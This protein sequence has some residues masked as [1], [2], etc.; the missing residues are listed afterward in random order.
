MSSPSIGIVG[1][2]SLLGK[3]LREA[4][5]ASKLAPSIQLIGAE[6]EEAGKVLLEEED[7]A[8]ITPLDERNLASADIIMLAGS[9]ESSRKAWSLLEKRGDTPVIDLTRSLEDIGSSRLVAP[10]AG[11]IAEPG[12]GGPLLVAH[13]AAVA[14]AMFLPRLSH[15]KL[16]RSVV[17]V[18]EPVSERGQ[19]GIEE[20]HQQTLKLFAFHSLPKAV[21]DTQVAYAMVA[22]YGA[23]SPHSLLQTELTIERHLASLLA[24][25]ACPMP[26][27][28]LIQAPV[29]HGYSLSVWAEFDSDVTAEELATDFFADNFDFRGDDEEI[30]TN[31]GSAGQGGIAVGDVRA[32]RNH[33][34]AFWFWLAADNLKLAADNAISVAESLWVE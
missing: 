21:Y 7:A 3:E 16:R 4:L 20:L 31:V 9:R 11:R 24:A 6:D 32:D 19:P 12:D 15:R 5:R 10:L 25:T 22:R 28:R 27:L 2:E 34:R 14:L 33:P 23:D 17:E 29:F 18:F 8:V 30:P 13:P 26:S 1:S